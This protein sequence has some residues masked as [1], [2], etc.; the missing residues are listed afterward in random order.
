MRAPFFGATSIGEEETK[1]NPK[2]S[3]TRRERQKMLVQEYVGDT[4]LIDG[5]RFCSQNKC[6][7]GQPPGPHCFR[8]IPFA[9]DPRTRHGGEQPCSPTLRRV[10]ATMLLGRL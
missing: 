6:G 4:E 2:E 5:R 8:E 3:G 10:R 9:P 7:P 1:H